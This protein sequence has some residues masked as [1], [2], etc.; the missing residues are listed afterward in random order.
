MTRG[1][2]ECKG[3]VTVLH[4]VAPL[5]VV[6][7][8]RSVYARLIKPGL[9][10]AL[11][12]T[13]LVVAAIPMALIAL[14]I[15]VTMGRPVLFRQRRVGL[16]GSPFEVLKFRTM[17]ED[18][19]EHHLPVV[20]DRRRTH[21]S[22]ADPRHTGI[23]RTLRKFSLDELPQLI[24][25]VR[26]EMS[27]VGPRPELESV[28]AT[29][30]AGLDQR[31]FVKP[32]LTGLWQI[33]ARGDGPMH[34]HGEWDLEYVERVSLLTDLSIIVRTPQAMLGDRVGD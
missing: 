28:V 27:V 23:G 22:T 7:A 19:R 16:D 4:P 8:P 9:D 30:P 33:S 1:D 2:D 20:H 32:G 18:R 26:G 25:V 3:T 17:K 14:L 11:G 21:K 15:L 5:P 31:H 6:V 29:Y 34:E 12:V 24:N 10:R 13:G